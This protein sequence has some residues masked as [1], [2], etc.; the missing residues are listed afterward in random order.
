MP[1]LVCA[2][3]VTIVYAIRV[4]GMS[5]EEMKQHLSIIPIADVTVTCLVKAGS[6]AFFPI[7]FGPLTGQKSID[8]DFDVESPRNQGAE[9]Q[10]SNRIK[11]KYYMGNNNEGTSNGDNE[12]LR[13]GGEYMN[14]VE[15]SC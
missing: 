6:A 15:K 13:G 11:L 1:L 9:I 5:I 12:N 8:A 7:P 4:T 3:R 10:Q 2:I 14:F